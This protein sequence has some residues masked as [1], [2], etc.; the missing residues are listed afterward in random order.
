VTPESSDV[1]EAVLAPDLSAH[2]SHGE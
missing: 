1:G 2:P